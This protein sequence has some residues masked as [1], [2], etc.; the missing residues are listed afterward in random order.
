VGISFSC[1]SFLSSQL[2]MSGKYTPQMNV[3]C[4]FG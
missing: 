3:M 4:S 1:I 2:L